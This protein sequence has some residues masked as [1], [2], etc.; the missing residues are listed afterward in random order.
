MKVLIGYDGSLSAEAALE[1]L[2]LGSVS[3]GVGK[4]AHCSV[5]VVRAYEVSQ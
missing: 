2:R 4:D 5:E 1:D 3:A